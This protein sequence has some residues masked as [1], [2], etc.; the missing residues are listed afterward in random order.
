MSYRHHRKFARQARISLKHT[1]TL[2]LS[3][4]LYHSSLPTDLPNY[5]LCPHS[6]GVDKFLL[7]GQYWYDH[8]KGSIRER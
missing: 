3:L 4:S 1:H 5:T 8:V 2:S 7:I 6:T